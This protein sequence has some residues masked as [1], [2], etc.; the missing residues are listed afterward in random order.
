MFD[1]SVRLAG[2]EGLTDSPS[3]FLRTTTFM[4]S[5]ESL[6]RAITLNCGV[7]L[8]LKLAGSREREAVHGASFELGEIGLGGSQSLAELL[9][10]G[11]GFFDL[12][13]L[14]GACGGRLDV[15]DVANDDAVLD[16]LVAAS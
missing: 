2:L 13:L 1:H 8:R 5:W 9:D 7:A 12:G 10:L 15:F 14:F 11:A 16:L 3:S 6:G 4:L